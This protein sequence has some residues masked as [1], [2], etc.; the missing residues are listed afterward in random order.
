MPW[1]EVV[2]PILPVLVDLF[3]QL[4]AKVPL[5]ELKQRWARWVGVLASIVNAIQPGVL[6]AI[7]VGILA[8]VAADEV[9]CT[10][11]RRISKAL[12]AYFWALSETSA[13]SPLF[14]S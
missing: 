1:Y 10:L 5:E 8:V 4:L 13:P 12:L 2:E 9:A 3:G 14:V 7:V 11:S 6:Q